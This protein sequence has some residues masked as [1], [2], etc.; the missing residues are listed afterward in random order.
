[1]DPRARSRAADAGRTVTLH[2]LHG[3]SLPFD[4]GSFD[5]VV[6]T[7]TLCSIADPERALG[8][9]RR[10]LVPDGRLLF[11][12]HGLAD[13]PRVQTWQH[14]LTPFQRV[15]GCGCE[16]DRDIRGLLDRTGFSFV[17]VRSLYQPGEPRVFGYFTLGEAVPVRVGTR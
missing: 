16:L 6:S 10:V 4:D 14:R 15:L 17:R 12:E 13:D 9:V 11:L 2:A 3:E 7:F 1:M 5:T 8:E